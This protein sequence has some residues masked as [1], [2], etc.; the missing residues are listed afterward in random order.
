MNLLNPEIGLEKHLQAKIYNALEGDVVNFI[1][2]NA[3]EPN[4]DIW[5]KSVMEGSAMKLDPEV[6]KDLYDLCMDV[7][8][9]LNFNDPVDFYIIGTNEVNADCI[10]ST[11]G[12]SPHIV[13][14]YAGLYDLMNEKELR[15]IVGHELGHLINKDALLARLVRFVYPSGTQLPI[16]LDFKVRI[17]NQLQE[18]VADRYGYLA[19]PDLEANVTSFYKISSGIDIAKLGVSLEDLL[20][21]N[22]KTLDFF[23]NGGGISDSTHPVNPIRIQALKLFATARTDREL[24][25]GMDQL[26]QILLKS[27]ADPMDPAMSNFLATA[28]IIAAKQDG[29]MTR[30]EYEKIVGQLSASHIF[31]SDFVEDIPEGDVEK[32]FINSV[33]EL[34]QRDSTILPLLLQYMIEVIMAD[35]DIHEAEVNF[36]YNIGTQMGLSRVEISN[37]FGGAI[38]RA[39][40]P[41]LTSLA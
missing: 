9:R 18:L 30:A 6:T 31:P 34:A 33:N 25:E 14:I 15:C 5:L 13:R 10:Y 21:K 41:S 22:D 27:G 40:I 20:R 11:D 29:T 2:K 8:R 3:G 17:H 7:K 4:E 37:I 12:K 36:I 16:A 39:F 24:E 28:G 32:I 26:I 19:C 23:I 35:N 1:L 38:Q